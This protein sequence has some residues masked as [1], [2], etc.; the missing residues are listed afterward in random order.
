MNLIK[1]QNSLRIIIYFFILIFIISLTKFSEAD[2]IALSGK[3]VLKKWSRAVV[4]VKLIIRYKIIIKGREINK[5]D[6]KIETIA[7]IIDPSGLGVF[8]LSAISYFDN[9]DHTEGN[10]GSDFKFKLKSKI[11]DVKIRLSDGQELPAKIILRDKDLD[12]GFLRPTIK[13]SKPITA[14]DLPDSYKPE[15]LDQIIILSSLGRM[16]GWVPSVSLNRIEAIIT[17]P[18]V[19]YFPEISH[20]TWKIGSPVFSTDGKVIGILVLR[21]SRGERFKKGLMIGGLKHTGILPVVLPASD[22]LYIIK[23]IPKE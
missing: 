11:I 12:I 6:K 1:R 23:Q 8:S 21:R 16:G 13:L 18:R 10:I 14:I 20:L 15:I 9:L 4:T 19:L 5:S 17:K 3:S 7:T 2:D 22:I